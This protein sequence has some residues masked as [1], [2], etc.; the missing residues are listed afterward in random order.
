MSESASDN[1]GAAS[2]LP[3]DV[4]KQVCSEVEMVT[5]EVIIKTRAESGSKIKKLQEQIADLESDLERSKRLAKYDLDDMARVNRSL[6]ADLEAVEEEKADMQEELEERFDEYDALNEDVE[7]FAETFA[8]QHEEMQQLESQ[9]KRLK[10]ENIKWNVLDTAKQKQIDELQAKVEKKSSE[11]LGT[12]IGKLWQEVGRLK[13]S[14]SASGGSHQAADS[15][16]SPPSSV[17]RNSSDDVS[18]LR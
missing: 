11:F 2:D 10:D 14:E 17:Y 12:E 1:I 6:R 8:N 13:T 18:Q 15:I 4:M 3:E 16:A 5:E 7:R 9:I